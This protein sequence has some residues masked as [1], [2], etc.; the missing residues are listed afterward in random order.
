ME[1]R[2]LHFETLTDAVAEGERLLVCGYDR[3]GNWGLAQTADHLA[4]IITMSRKG[5]PWYFPWPITAVARWWMG[6]TILGRKIVRRRF[7]APKYLQPTVE[8]DPR[9]ALDRF[10]VAVE[11]FEGAGDT[12]APH[13]IFG[14]L[15]RDEWRQ[16]HLWH[17]EHH[18]S[19]LLPHSQV[20]A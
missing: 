6:S 12:V 10:R 8:V 14:R 1:R 3:A 15:T 18:F 13:P 17:C 4:T 19:F 5:F 7:P 2:T 16:A 9:G 20:S 11:L